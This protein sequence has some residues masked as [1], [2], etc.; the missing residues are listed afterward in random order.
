MREKPVNSSLVAKRENVLE[1]IFF[2]VVA[3]VKPI[4]YIQKLLVATIILFFGD[5]SDA[6]LAQVLETKYTGSV[7]FIF[8]KSS[9]LL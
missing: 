6:S 3:N 2:V 4:E 8:G 5:F 1:L 9:M 7:G